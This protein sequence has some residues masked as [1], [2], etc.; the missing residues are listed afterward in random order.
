MW[1]E[2]VLEIFKYKAMW[3]VVGSKMWERKCV[4]D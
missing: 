3:S 4:D 2:P 1:S